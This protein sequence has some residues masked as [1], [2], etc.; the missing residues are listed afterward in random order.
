MDTQTW[1]KAPFGTLH[2]GNQDPFRMSE[3]DKSDGSLGV[4]LIRNLDDTR[5]SSNLALQ[6][7]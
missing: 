2:L 1:Y 3:G 4:L 7:C 6:I 5:Y